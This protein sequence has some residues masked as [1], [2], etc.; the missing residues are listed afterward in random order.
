MQRIIPFGTGYAQSAEFSVDEGQTIKFWIARED[1]TTTPGQHAFA[2]LQLRG[3][4]DDDDN[5][6]WT[7]VAELTGDAPSYDLIGVDENLIYRWVRKDAVPT[8]AL[9]RSQD[10]AYSRTQRAAVDPRQPVFEHPTL[11]LLFKVQS[12]NDPA[13]DE[14]GVLDFLVPATDPTEFGAILGTAPDTTVSGVGAAASIRVAYDPTGPS[15]YAEFFIDDGTGNSPFDWS[16]YLDSF[17]YVTLVTECGGEDG[18]PLLSS[19]RIDSNTGTP[20]HDATA[21]ATTLT[22]PLPLGV[23]GNLQGYDPLL[24]FA[25]GSTF[26]VGL[27]KRPGQED[28]VIFD[29][30]P[31]TGRFT[32]DRN[33]VPARLSASPFDTADENVA[34]S[35]VEGNTVFPMIENGNQRTLNDDNTVTPLNDP[36]EY[37]WRRSCN[38]SPGVWLNTGWRA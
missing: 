20:A 6:R 31:R 4:Q 1:H 38:S 33:D 17:S 8:I 16:E 19:I 36:G 12:G 21:T 30:G 34:M 11:P 18:E 32:L 24:F 9:Y 26:F 10:G 37:E 14:L 15:A 35:I 29:L 27:V 28:G 7:T 22:V 5:Y 2:E 13:S 3:D 23:D 25:E